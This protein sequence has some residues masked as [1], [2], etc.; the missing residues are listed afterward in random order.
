MFSDISSPKAFSRRAS[1]MGV[2]V[3]M[4]PP[5]AAGVGV[6]LGEDRAEVTCRPADVAH[7]LVSREVE[8]LG[9]RVEVAER[10]ALHR[11]HELLE[12]RGVA[13]ELLEH[14]LAGVL[15]LVL[16]L[17]GAQRLGQIA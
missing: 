12:A 13:V 2:S 1:A 9:E 14:R 10:D 7:R 16:G 3:G 4:N 15:D 17:A 6:A 5:P 11:F 8:L